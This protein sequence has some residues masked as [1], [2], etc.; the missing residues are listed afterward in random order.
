M[1]RGEKIRK[2]REKKSLSQT[3]ASRY[4]GVSKQTLYKY[5]NDVI[6]NIPS[7]IIERM[8]KLYDTTPAYI[9]GWEDEG[10]NK[11]PLGEMGESY[12]Y[13]ERLR[14]YSH[15]KIIAAL[16]FIDA[17]ERLTPDRRVAVESLLKS[18]GS[19]PSLHQM[20]G[21]TTT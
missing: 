12:I 10:G 13:N 1:E 8:A 9:M 15:E 7:N 3:D 2:L 4:L 5:E 18:V 6:T 11:T 20:P 17:F 14:Q 21:D 16:N 19:V